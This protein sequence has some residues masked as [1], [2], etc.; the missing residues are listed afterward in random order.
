M[1]HEIHLVTDDDS[2]DKLIRRRLASLPEGLLLPDGTAARGA[3]IERT[4]TIDA[5]RESLRVG[6]A[7]ALI[8]L[9]GSVRGQ[10]TDVQSTD[11]SPAAEFLKEI[12]QTKIPI[13][14]VEQA[15]LEKLEFEVLRRS[16]VAI[17]RPPPVVSFN[18]AYPVDT[19]RY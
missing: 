10:T 4:S 18:H 15:S 12:C 14:V 16:D 13:I 3:F 1:T 11:G 6:P 19:Q 2:I 5:E 7:P 8:I 9:D 17:W